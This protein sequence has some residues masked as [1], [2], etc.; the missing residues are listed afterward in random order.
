MAFVMSLCDLPTAK[1]AFCL[2][3]VRVG[4]LASHADDDGRLAITSL[5]R[6]SLMALPFAIGRSLVHCRL[7][8]R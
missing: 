1:I 8:S 4:T 3:A 2:R 7:A 6:W 5:T